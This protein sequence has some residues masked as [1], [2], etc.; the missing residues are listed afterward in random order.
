MFNLPFIEQLSWQFLT[1]VT[2]TLYVM[3]CIC[4]H[5]NESLQVSNVYNIY[6]YWNYIDYRKLCFGP[7]HHFCST[8]MQFVKTFT[9]DC[10]CSNSNNPNSFPKTSPY[11]YGYTSSRIYYGVKNL[12]SFVCLTEFYVW[13]LIH[14]YSNAFF[15]HIHIKKCQN[16][17]LCLIL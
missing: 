15:I 16:T 12:C 4:T 14:N 8:T 3:L 2:S 10:H 5:I 6:T 11:K 9:V 17:T 7:T 13:R 1:E